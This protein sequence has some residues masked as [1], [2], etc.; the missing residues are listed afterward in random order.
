MFGVTSQ[1]KKST[2]S[3]LIQA[4]FSVLNTHLS[5]WYPNL[6][7]A[8]DNNGRCPRQK[9]VFGIL[10]LIYIHLRR[11]SLS[12]MDQISCL[13]KVSLSLIDQISCLKEVCKYF[14]LY[15]GIIEKLL[16]PI[17]LNAG[18]CFKMSMRLL[19]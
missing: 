17:S 16:K 2:N 11:V 18:F 5:W 7:R 8:Y 4:L 6:T 12:L 13:K 15:S 9:F 1:Q 19:D 14:Q 3:S 10:Q